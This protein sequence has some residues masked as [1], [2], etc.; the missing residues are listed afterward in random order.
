LN[1]L[2][3]L[4]VKPAIVALLEGGEGTRMSGSVHLDGARTV[5]LKNFV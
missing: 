2:K 3:L 1:D 4:N 5:W